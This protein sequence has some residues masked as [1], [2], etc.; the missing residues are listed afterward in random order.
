MHGPSVLA[1]ALALALAPGALG[2]AHVQCQDGTPVT[3]PTIG[4]HER[5]LHEFACSALRSDEEQ[6]ELRV[7]VVRSR[8]GPR[9]MV[10]E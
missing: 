2:A 1:I 10:R 7:F 6:M 4:K 9:A 8:T 3:D 5:R